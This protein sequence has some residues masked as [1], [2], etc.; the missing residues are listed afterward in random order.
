MKVAHDIDDIYS[1]FVLQP[2]AGP[3]SDR[4]FCVLCGES[5]SSPEAAKDC[6]VSH[7]PATTADKAPESPS[8][9]S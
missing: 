9:R 2:E 7:I 3:G 5:Y 6:V 1:A 8:K 4:H